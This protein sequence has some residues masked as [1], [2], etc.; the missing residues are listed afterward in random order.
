MVLKPKSARIWQKI[1]EF[2][3]KC[4]K[5]G[6]IDEFKDKN[7]IFEHPETQN[8]VNLMQKSSKNYQ[9]SSL[10]PPKQV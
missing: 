1:W 6:K 5:F 8:Q 10:Y 9:N 4:T 7:V 3:L 2:W